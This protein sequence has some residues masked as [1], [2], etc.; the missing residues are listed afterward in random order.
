MPERALVL[1]L[2]RARE[3]IEKWRLE[4]N[5]ERPHSSL[6]NLPPEEFVK[7][8]LAGAKRQYRNRGLQP[9]AVLNGVS[10]QD[11][12]ET[13]AFNTNEIF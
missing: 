7:K 6:G 12:V 5:T 8:G 10:P 9:K 11:R 2:T 3:N 1:T 13:T 4:Y